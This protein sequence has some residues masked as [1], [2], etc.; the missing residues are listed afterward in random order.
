[1][2][3]LSASIIRIFDRHGERKV[4]MK[5]RMKFLIRKLG[6]D[7]FRELVEEERAKLEVD[8]TWNDFLK[9]IPEHETAT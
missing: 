1:M 5:A 8:P 7:K 3:P 2:I 9:D 4:R 6:F